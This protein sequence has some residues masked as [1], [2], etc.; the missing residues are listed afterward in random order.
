M[1]SILDAISNVPAATSSQE[2]S[3][4]L[5]T[6][7]KLNRLGSHG[8]SAPTDVSTK[9][10]LGDI[11]DEILDLLD[12]FQSPTDQGLRA[13]LTEIISTAIKL[14]SALRK[15]S[16]RVDFDYDPSTGN[17]Q[18]WDFVDDLATNGSMA[19][20]SPN[21][22]PAAL[23]PSESF[24][25]FPRITGFF[26]PDSARPRIL[27]AGWALPHDSPAFREAFQEMKHIDHV[28]KE[29]NRSLRRGSSAQSSPVIGKR[30]GDWPA[31]HRGYN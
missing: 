7:D 31:S 24:M 26:E 4:R 13:K 21:E 29:F 15:D 23:L 8:P 22:I 28:T 11:I 3:W 18:E 1:D 30:P 27:H 5:T 19:V 20:N 17:W 2:L 16:C 6:V 9:P 12:Y 14:W 10:S 25:L